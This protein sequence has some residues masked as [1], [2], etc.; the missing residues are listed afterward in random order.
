MATVD[1][2]PRGRGFDSS[3]GYFHHA[4]DYYTEVAVGDNSCNRSV[5]D[6]WEDRGPAYALNETKEYEEYIL[7]DR[8]LE[9]I[10][11][12][13]PSQPL[14]IYYA[15]HLVHAPLQV[16][17]SQRANA[18]PRPVLEFVVF[19]P[20][21]DL[22]SRFPMFTS[23]ATRSSTMSI[24]GFTTPWSPVWTTLSAISPRH[25]TKVVSGT[26]CCGSRPATMEGLSTS[27]EVPRA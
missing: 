7:R 15:M 2:T 23:N 1:H 24:A 26:T 20:L 11:A 10:D 22:G 4:N 5:V 6:I 8:V 18:L 17:C 3:L 13:D 27:A 19:S 21:R 16:R 12:H 25:F 9:I 14:F